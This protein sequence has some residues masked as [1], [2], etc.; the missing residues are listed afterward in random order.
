[1]VAF[2]QPKIQIYLNLISI[3]SLFNLV[4]VFFPGKV[5]HTFL[6]G[7]FGIPHSV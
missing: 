3:F 6:I 5:S 7:I 4:K 1:M 2:K